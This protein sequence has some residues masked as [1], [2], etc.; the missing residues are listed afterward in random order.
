MTTTALILLGLAV[1]VAACFAAA[2]YVDTRRAADREHDTRPAE[3]RIDQ[4]RIEHDE[5][6]YAE[7]TT[8]PRNRMR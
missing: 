5:E 2:W 8:D 4:H 3:S 7:V 6:L 1:I